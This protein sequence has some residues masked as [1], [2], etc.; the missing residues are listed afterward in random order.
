MRI[1]GSYMRFIDVI[2]IINA[3]VFILTLIDP[4]LV[5]TTLALMPAQILE[6]PW[7]IVTSMF[8][9]G[10]FEHLFMNM[11][12]L[13][14][15]GMYIERIIDEKDLI[16]LYFIGGIAGSLFYIFFAFFSPFTPINSVVVGASGAL[17]A[18]GGALAVL[19]PYM[20]VIIFPF[21]V[22]MPMW[23][24]EVIIFLIV[25]LFPNVAWEG[26]LGGLIAGVLFAYHYRK[27]GRHWET[28]YYTTRYY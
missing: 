19:R 2:I 1:A 27:K 5:M 28:V 22:P 17:F 12:A 7:T 26:H 14:F 25:S 21:P 13:Y 10:G 9:H 11:L 6:K 23:M 18:I 24:A 4:F 16:R 20:Q 8:V 15:F 3:L